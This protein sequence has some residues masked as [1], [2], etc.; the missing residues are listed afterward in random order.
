MK[1]VPAAEISVAGILLLF[2]D[3]RKKMRMN[4]WK[5]TR[6][7]TSD[8]DRNNGSSDPQV[9]LVIQQNNSAE[10]KIQGIRKYGRKRFTL[11]IFSIDEALPPIIDDA[12]EYLPSDIRASVVLDYLR[13]PDLSQDLAVLCRDR[14][15][16]LIASGKKLRTEGAL[17][18]TT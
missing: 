14:N 7:D 18:P 2:L 12:R 10:S 5:C 9:I 11:D 13:H 6:N 17:T 15:I 8:A 16:P 3:T 1:H 4:D